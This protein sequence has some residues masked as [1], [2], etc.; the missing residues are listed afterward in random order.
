[1]TFGS[2]N[3]ANKNVAHIMSHGKQIKVVKPP[4]FQ[5]NFEFASGVGDDELMKE[6]E[7]GGR[8]ESGKK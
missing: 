5:V 3:F 1:M 2:R 4:D 8:A 7:R 6:V